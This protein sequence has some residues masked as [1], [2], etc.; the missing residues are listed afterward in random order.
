MCEKVTSFKYNKSIGH[1]ECKN[2]GSRIAINPND[3]P[4]MENYYKN[5]KKV[6]ISWLR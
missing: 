2:C 3:K 6:D 1:S 5:N 4:S